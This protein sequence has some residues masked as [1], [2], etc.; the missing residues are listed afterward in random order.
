MAAE[1]Q[2]DDDGT[3]LRQTAALQQT[4]VRRRRI[5]SAARAVVIVLVAVGLALTVRDALE[6]LNH[7]QRRWSQQ[8]GWQWLMLAAVL[9]GVGLV[10][11]GVYWH[12]VLWAFGQRPLLGRSVAAHLLGHLGKYVP[13]KA[14]VVVIRSG[15]IAGPGVQPIAAGAAVFVETLTMMATGAAL[16]AV[17]IGVSDADRW[18]IGLAVALAVAASLPTAPP[19]FRQAIRRFADG[20]VGERWSLPGNAIDWPLFCSGWLWMSCGWLFIGGSFACVLLASRGVVVLPP[21]SGEL[22]GQDLAIAAAAMG[23]AVVAGF[24][25]LVPGG[26]GV[27][28]L[29]VAAVLTPRVGPGAALMAAVLAR[30]IFLSV[31]V[32]IAAA[33]W[34]YLRQ[35]RPAS[36]ADAATGAVT[37]G[38]R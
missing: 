2:G 13:G 26:A 15:A 17:V 7:Q 16:A 30:L 12:R 24:V 33:A 1:P 23:L 25:S 10:P 32:L 11:A 34:I 4:A 38:Q 8:I 9:Y 18:V 37:G 22:T 6:Q 19:L 5:K 36:D 28:E 20:R 21:G 29:V 31:E 27:R 14:M 35:S 3:L